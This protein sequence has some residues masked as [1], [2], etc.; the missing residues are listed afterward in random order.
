MKVKNTP[1]KAFKPDTLC[2]GFPFLLVW[3]RAEEL[4]TT[5]S[6]QKKKAVCKPLY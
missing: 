3:S 5:S 6:A 1:L 4:I 2:E